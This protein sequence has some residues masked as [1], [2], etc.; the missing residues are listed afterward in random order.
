MSGANPF[1]SHPIWAHAMSGAAR[2]SARAQIAFVRSLVDEVARHAP[3]SARAQA[4]SIQI[5]EEL[6][7]L[8]SLL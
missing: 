8:R 2:P 5:E 4:I 1:A 3:A 7:R 6:A